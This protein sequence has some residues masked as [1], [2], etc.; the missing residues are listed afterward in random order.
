MKNLTARVICAVAN[1]A[2]GK[3][4]GGG[5][6]RYVTIGITILFVVLAIMLRRKD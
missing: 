3:A 4:T 6:M 1:G 2:C 5:A